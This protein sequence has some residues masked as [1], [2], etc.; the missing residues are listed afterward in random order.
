MKLLLSAGALCHQK[1][2][3]GITPPR[4]APHYYPN[5]KAPAVILEQVS[6]GYLDLQ[7]GCRVCISLVYHVPFHFEEALRINSRHPS[8]SVSDH[9]L[10]A[11]YFS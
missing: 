11:V 2:I 1:D 3:R 5:L 8:R 9:A 4:L 10:L 6:V 7:D